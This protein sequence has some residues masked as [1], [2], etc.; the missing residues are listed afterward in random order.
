MGRKSLPLATI[1]AYNRSSFSGNDCRPLTD[2][3]VR[4]SNAR[5]MLQKHIY[6]RRRA[7]DTRP[8]RLAL[9]A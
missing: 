9:A 2:R 1:A 8:A 3:V 4:R 6:L 5:L 7:I